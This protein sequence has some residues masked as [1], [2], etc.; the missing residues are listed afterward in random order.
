MTH[1]PDKSHLNLCKEKLPLWEVLLNG[2]GL[3]E[4]LGAETG[5]LTHTELSLIRLRLAQEPPTCLEPCIV[6][7]AQTS[8][9][10]LWT[11]GCRITHSLSPPLASARIQEEGFVVSLSHSAFSLPRLLVELPEPRLNFCPISSTDQCLARII[12]A[13][14]RLG[15]SQTPV[16][17]LCL[18]RQS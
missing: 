9:C 12:S 3:Q 5:S 7:L 4:T 17:A 10:R 6:F 18:S 14:E 15:R 11:R 8:G 13:L 1:C 2:C 16:L